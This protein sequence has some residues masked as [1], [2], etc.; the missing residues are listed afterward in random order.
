MALAMTAPVCPG[1]HEPLPA[2]LARLNAVYCCKPCRA[3][4]IDRILAE[5]MAKPPPPSRKKKRAA[6][7]VKRKPSCP[8]C[9]DDLPAGSTEQFCDAECECEHAIDVAQASA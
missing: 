3:R 6:A 9:G 4:H 1:C 2:P 7:G 5:E 8:W